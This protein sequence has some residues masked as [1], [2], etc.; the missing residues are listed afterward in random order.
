MAFL[1]NSAFLKDCAFSF[2]FLT[3]ALFTGI[4]VFNIA[5]A[6]LGINERKAD[7]VQLAP[8]NVATEPKSFG[9]T[10]AQNVTVPN[11]DISTEN[12]YASRKV[13]MTLQKAAIEKMQAKL[14]GQMRTT[15]GKK[16]QDSPRLSALERQ[17]IVPT[18]KR[19]MPIRQRSNPKRLPPIV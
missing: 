12:Q 14:A 17:I 4:I 3:H 15:I 11:S 8:A 16:P 2:S 6:D 19:R 13:D 1:K 10:A 5:L 9:S 7:N 18:T